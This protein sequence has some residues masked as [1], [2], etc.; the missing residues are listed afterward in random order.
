MTLVAWACRAI[1]A[2][3]LGETDAGMTVGQCCE[4]GHGTTPDH[5]LAL[6]WYLFALNGMEDDKTKARI[7]FYIGGPC[8]LCLLL[9]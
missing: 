4:F 2:V 1:K 5:Q 8:R 9:L 6:Q 3:K 7:Y